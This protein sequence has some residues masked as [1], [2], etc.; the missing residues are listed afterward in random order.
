MKKAASGLAVFMVFAAAAK[1][2][3]LFS[4]SFG[5]PDGALVAVSTNL[6]MH[7]SGLTDEVMVASGRVVLTEANTEDVHALLA[8]QPYSA[9][10]STNVFY[11]SFKVKF[12]ALPSGNGAY[13]AHFK[14]SGN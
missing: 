8:G 5:Y 3:L 14:D 7:H 12:T 6:W 9:S 10:G 11:A 2:V 1:A 4:D 13:F